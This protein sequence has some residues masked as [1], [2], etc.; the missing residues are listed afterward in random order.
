MV[1]YHNGLL[2]LYLNIEAHIAAFVA[3]FVSPSTTRN[4]TTVGTENE[5]S[6]DTNLGSLCGS[7]E[8]NTFQ[9][10]SGAICARCS[11]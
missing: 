10:Q 8:G 6:L 4:N 11:P 5:L 3:G 2:D 9:H 1:V 7:A